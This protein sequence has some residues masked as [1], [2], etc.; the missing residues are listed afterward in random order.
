MN[1]GGSEAAAAELTIRLLGAADVE[2][3]CRDLAALLVDAIEGG[4]SVGFVWPIDDAQVDAFWRGI[5]ADVAA[6]TCDVIVAE[7]GGEIVGSIQLA[8]SWKPNQA[9]RADV[10]KLLVARR[11]RRK[12]IGRCLMDAVEARALE[13]GRWLL[14][15][16]TRT[17][18]EADSLYRRL[19]WIDIGTIPDYA[20]DPD[21][22]FAA[23]TFFYRRLRAAR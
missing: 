14:T 19:G 12:G 11:E 22:T 18:S 21:G 16:D 20:S 10:Q 8:R 9:H 4:A 5:A 23:C 1:Q 17:G 7:R 3:R 6:G 2:A 13:T 15:L